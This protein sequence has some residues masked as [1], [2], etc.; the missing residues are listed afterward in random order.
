[1]KFTS[2]EEDLIASIRNFRNSKHNYS[3]GLEYEARRLFEELM[4]KDESSKEYKE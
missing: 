2:K 4:E 1:M 3:R